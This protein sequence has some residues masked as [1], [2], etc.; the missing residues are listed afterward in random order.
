[1]EP[2]SGSA[3]AGVRVELYVRSLAP[4]ESRRTVER[5]VDRLDR[6]A[7]DGAIE[8]FRV[9]PTGAE[10]PP[11][12]ADAV[13]AFGEFL[14]HRIAVFDDWA[15]ATDRSLGSLFDRRAVTSAFTGET[16]DA[17]HMPTMVMA[18]YAGS[19]LR[20]VSPC[21]E[22]GERV[23]VA[24]RLDALARP[25]RVDVGEQLPGTGLVPPPGP[26]TPAE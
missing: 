23:T 21:E 25:E 11:R 26:T 10:L 18:E 5:V 4:R 1:M 2:T 16:H 8:G 9:V 3:D 22:D 7:A 13:T 12:P 6:L 24:A 17:I 14:L 15:Q 20:F 19:A